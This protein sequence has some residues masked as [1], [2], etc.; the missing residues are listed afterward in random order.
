M[1][2]FLRSSSGPPIPGKEGVVV[3]K[4]AQAPL[5]PLVP[6]VA[7]PYLELIRFHK[8]HFLSCLANTYL[9]RRGPKA[10]RIYPHVLAIRY[11]GDIV[12]LVQASWH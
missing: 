3:A 4:N 10:H 8:V 11:V 1:A 6:E 2:P 7:Q 9:I 12:P 5:F